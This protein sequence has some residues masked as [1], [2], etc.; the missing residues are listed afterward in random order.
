MLVGAYHPHLTQHGLGKGR[1]YTERDKPQYRKR[2]Y[3]YIDMY[4]HDCV[5]LIDMEYYDIAQQ[6]STCSNIVVVKS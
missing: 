3:I 2:Q 5:Y 1:Q 6:Y 4:M